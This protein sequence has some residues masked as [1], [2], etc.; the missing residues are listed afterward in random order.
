MTWLSDIVRAGFDGTPHDMSLRRF[1]HNL[2]VLQTVQNGVAAHFTGVDPCGQ[3]AREEPSIR[4]T[5]DSE[6]E[7]AAA[8]R[9]NATVPTPNLPTP[10]KTNDAMAPL[11]F[12]DSFARVDG[13]LG[14]GW[15]EGWAATHNFSQ[16]GVFRNAAVVVGPTVRKG[17]YPPPG[18]NSAMGGCPTLSAGEIFPGIGLIIGFAMDL[19]TKDDEGNP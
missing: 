6:D 11:P 3:Q 15:V 12:S 9:S 14:N 18:N 10:A 13:A 1:T 5:D 4:L 16:L 19:T 17:K 7:Q 2:Q 8:A